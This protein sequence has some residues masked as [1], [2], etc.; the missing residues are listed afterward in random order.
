MSILAGGNKET[1]GQTASDL[2]IQEDG[3]GE[4]G[5][6]NFAKVEDKS[7]VNVYHAFTPSFS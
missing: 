5:E 7:N 6:A 2:T 1:S 4:I 3:P